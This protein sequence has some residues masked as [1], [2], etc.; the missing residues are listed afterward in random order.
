MVIRIEVN[1]YHH[2]GIKDLAEGLSVSATSDDGLIEAIENPYYPY[3]LGVQWHP[4]LSYENNKYSKKIF[5][6]FV[7]NSNAG[8]N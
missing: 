5:K 6:D 1:S 7:K 3:M 2:E 4:E 8:R